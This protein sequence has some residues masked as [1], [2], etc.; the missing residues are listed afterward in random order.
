MA[1]EY[2]IVWRESACLD[3]MNTGSDRRDK[4]CYML[5]H[6]GEYVNAICDPF[7]ENPH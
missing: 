3:L 1:Y 5:I 2:F 6:R 7:W 4:I